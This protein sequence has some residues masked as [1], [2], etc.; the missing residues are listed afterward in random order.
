MNFQQPVLYEYPVDPAAFFQ[1]IQYQSLLHFEYLFQP[2]YLKAFAQ[3]QQAIVRKPFEYNYDLDNL[4]ISAGNLRAFHRMSACKNLY[5]SSIKIYTA[6]FTA[7]YKPN[8][9]LEQTY[10]GI[11]PNFL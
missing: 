1:A 6:R 4:Y 5:D 11:K 10:Q 2:G 7:Q 3:L 9:Q 8:C